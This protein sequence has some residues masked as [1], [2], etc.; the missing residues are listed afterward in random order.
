MG[1]ALMGL[2]EARWWLGELAGS[3]VCREQAYR[4]FRDRGDPF[5]AA[6]AA[7]TLC[8]DYRKQYGDTAS[9]GGW[10][11]QAA[12][13]VQ[14]HGL[15]ELRGWL[16]FASSVD[17]EDPVRSEQ[18]AREAHTLAIASGDRDLE[19][20]ALSQTGVAL[21]DQGRVDAGVRCLDESMAVSLG[22]GGNPGTVVFTSCMMMTSCSRAA[23][24][25]RAV[26]WVRA[27]VAFTEEFGCPFLYAECRILYGGVL[28][29]TGEWHQAEQEL[30]AG[31][32]LARGA[33]P[34]LQRL[35]VAGLA[36][37]WLDQGRV[38][39]A[40][41]LLSGHEDHAETLSVLARI[42]LRNGTPD[43]AKATLRRRLATIGTQQLESGLLLELL[44]DAELASGD[45][46]VAAD[47]GREL[48]ELGSSVGCELF[49]ARG[50]RLLGRAKAAVG[51]TA[52]AR[53]YLDQA[54]VA[55]ARLEM[56]HEAAR[57]RMLLAATLRVTE[58]EV[59]KAEAQS[60]FAT[61]EDLGAGPDADAAAALLREL[62][63]KAS[64]RGPRGR[65]GLT[66]RE[67]Q[68]LRL[69]GEGLSNPEIAARLFLSRKT[70]EHHVAHVLT[71]LGLRGRAEAA[72]EAVRRSGAETF[73]SK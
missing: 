3:M 47:L 25:A 55:F 67:E 7:V 57:T 63:V 8:L 32:A 11:D 34:A 66:K 12:R 65:G 56:R 21:V 45:V 38:D 27:S 17:C 72:V 70:V 46:E 59:A 30:I 54:L 48:V 24:F 6:Y 22:A 28:T 58:P 40:E 4:I 73:S 39:E 60:A 44:G 50:A 41:R 69:L 19:L 29:A 9:S 51:E 52:P 2:G 61:F 49:R 64:R 16:L 31:L 14:D 5:Q 53:Q 10:L 23:E 15:D 13:L 26:Q 20:C 68:I 43:A 42:Q 1:E 36:E 35:A 37:L 62:G 71:K 18:L 33:V